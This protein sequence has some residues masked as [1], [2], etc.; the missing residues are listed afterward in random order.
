MNPDTPPCHHCFDF[1]DIAGRCRHCGLPASGAFPLDADEIDLLTACP[2]ADLCPDCDGPMLSG[3][4][5]TSYC[6]ACD[7]TDEPCDPP[8]VIDDSI[9]EDQLDEILQPDIGGSD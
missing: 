2:V 1:A 5:G 9:S 7:Y 4:G 8:T 3:L 6:S